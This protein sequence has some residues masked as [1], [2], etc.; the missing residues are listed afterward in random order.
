MPGTPPPGIPTSNLLLF[1]QT[2][3]SPAAWNPI[4]NL[5]DYTGPQSTSTVVDVSKHGDTFRRKI[6]TL[7]DA[8][9]LAFPCWFDPSQPTLAGNPQGMLELYNNQTAYET[10][11]I[12]FVD[13]SGNIVPASAA[14]NG[15][16]LLFNGYVTKFS[17]KEPVAGVYS[18]D[19][20]ITIDG[21][22]TPLWQTT[23]MPAGQRYDP[24]TGV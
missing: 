1:L 14:N 20:E 17:L 8:G 16:Q 21:K 13:S 11:L 22:P 23:T 4:A 7:M 2:T 6:K 3:A 18:A 15:P 24:V 19:T 9:I 10:F 12:A 5:G